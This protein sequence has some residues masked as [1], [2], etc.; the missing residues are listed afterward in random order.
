V[1]VQGTNKH[2]TRCQEL[3][4]AVLVCSSRTR[5]WRD[6]FG[7]L[8]RPTLNPAPTGLA[9]PSSSL[10]SLSFHPE[11]IA[12]GTASWGEHEAGRLKLPAVGGHWWHACLPPIGLRIWNGSSVKQD[13]YSP[14]G[15][16]PGTA[17]GLAGIWDGCRNSYFWRLG[18]GNH[19]AQSIYKRR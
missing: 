9:T 19:V 6:L 5:N 18:V 15:R 4:A 7:A 11:N 3:S 14:F 2:A 10:D 17:G 16:L 8:G 12:N 13:V 1:G